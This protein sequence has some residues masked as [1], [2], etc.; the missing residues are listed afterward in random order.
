MTLQFCS[1][2]HLEFSQNKAYL[3]SN[4][5]IPQADVLLLAGDVVPFA[6][7]DGQE[8]FFRF[9]S[10]NFKYTY[11]LPGNHEYYG[12]DAAVKSGTLKEEIKANV[13]LVNNISVNHGDVRL[14]FSTLWSRISPANDWLIEK[15]VSDF[16]AILHNGY[17]FSAP[18]FNF[19]HRR[20]LNF[21][22]EELQKE[23]A[24]KTVV[25][26]H[27]VPTFL[28][29]PPQYKG[30]IINEAFAVE[31]HDFIHDGKAAAWLYGH[32]HVNIPEFTIG[33]TRMM[34]NQLGYVERSEHRLFDR[35][36][37]FSL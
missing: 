17:R 29:Y 31:L 34:T 2:L 32:H 25:I 26:T 12:T 14:V 33:E 6:S 19:L 1:D 30:S 5:L 8:D 11:W 16:D 20:C 3:T 22:T 36:K 27:H 35:S 28:N 10:K 7:R 23:E 4:P 24:G 9:V 18:A 37:T 13:F 21:L 15:S